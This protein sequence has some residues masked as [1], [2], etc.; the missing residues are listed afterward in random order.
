M[1]LR[2]VMNAGSILQYATLVSMLIG[3]VSVAVAFFIHRETAKTQIFLALSARYD[4]LLQS[5]SAILWLATPGDA[6]LPE[7]DCQLTVSAL[8]F[9]TLVSLAYYLFR[10]HRIPK[11]MWQLMLSSAER[12]MRSP[13]F[14]REWEDLRPEFESFPEF[15]A[16]VSS[17]QAGTRK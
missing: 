17:V 1:Y 2:D 5:S 15:A 7:R 13:L 10:D 8:R 12:R 3:A 14:L 4:E 9:C 11:R 16:L 6:K